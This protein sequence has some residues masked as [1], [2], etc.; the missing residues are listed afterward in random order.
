MISVITVIANTCGVLT[1]SRAQSWAV[2]TLSLHVSVTHAVMVT[3]FTEYRNDS[4]KVEQSD[5]LDYCS[6]NILAITSAMDGMYLPRALKLGLAS[7]PA[8]EQGKLDLKCGC[9]GELVLLGICLTQTC[10]HM[11]CMLT[12]HCALRQ[13]MHSVSHTWASR[14]LTIHKYIHIHNTYKASQCINI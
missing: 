2:Y 4:C 13:H 1:T 14:S 12:V 10:V 7:E 5:S 8:S 11:S 9:R 3:P 6:A